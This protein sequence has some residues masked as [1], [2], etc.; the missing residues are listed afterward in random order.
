MVQGYK[1][2]KSLGKLYS[3]ISWMWQIFQI[4]KKL[5]YSCCENISTNLLLTFSIENHII[6]KNII[7]KK[8]WT[9]GKAATSLYEN[10]AVEG[11]SSILLANFIPDDIL[12]PT[13]HGL[14]E[15]THYMRGARGA[16][17]IFSGELYIVWNFGGYMQ[18]YTYKTSLY[19][20][21]ETS[22]I[23]ACGAMTHFRPKWS[24]FGPK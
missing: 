7:W 22:R 15:R 17:P 18:V 13:L 2:I 6:I 14:F 4:G 12:N 16:P 24:H 10:Y 23:S 1:F 11:N 5:Q 21:F 20:K 9:K 19:G 3:D 8:I